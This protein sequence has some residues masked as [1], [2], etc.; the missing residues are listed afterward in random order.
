MGSD[1]W[2]IF[3]DSTEKSSKRE[4]HF[5]FENQW[6]LEADYEKVFVDN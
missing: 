6:L 4:K 5:F 1:H 2:P 3:L